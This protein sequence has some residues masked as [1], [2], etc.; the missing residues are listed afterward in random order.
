MLFDQQSADNRSE[1]SNLLDVIHDRYF[2]LSQLTYDESKQELRLYLGEKRKGLYDQR[3]LKI[4]GVTG[5]NVT[6]DDE[7]GIYQ[8]FSL[9]K[10]RARPIIILDAAAIG[11]E[12]KVR[13]GWKIEVKALI[14]GQK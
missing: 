11:M 14:E 3:E 12:I 13:E 1:W 2:D 7:I 5:V 4:S 9:E 8:L 10:D 6:Y